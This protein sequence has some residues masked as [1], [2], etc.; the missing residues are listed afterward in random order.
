[1]G[2]F[3]RLTHSQAEIFLVFPLSLLPTEKFAFFGSATCIMVPVSVDALSVVQPSLPIKRK[4]RC[5]SNSLYSMILE[6]AERV[7]GQRVF[8]SCDPSCS[9]RTSPPPL[10]TFGLGSVFRTRLNSGRVRLLRDSYLYHTFPYTSTFDTIC[11][12]FVKK[13]RL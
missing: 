9:K 1:V 4:Q 12:T 13:I 5:A 8:P 6:A 3:H 10:M 2:G 7:I 11:P